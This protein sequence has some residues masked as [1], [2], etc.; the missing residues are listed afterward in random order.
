[1]ILDLIAAASMLLTAPT[2]ISST[3]AAYDGTS[4]KLNGNVELEH[5]LGLM[6]SQEALL[7]KDPF[8]QIHLKDG[9]IITLK[10][11]GKILCSSADLDLDAMEGKLL[12]AEDKKIQFEHEA[13]KLGCLAAEL[14][15][16]HAKEPTLSNMK[17]L[18]EVEI[19]YEGDLSLM[20][21]EATYEKEPVAI[22]TA[23]PGVNA[24]CVI[25]RGDDRMEAKKVQFFPN[26]GKVVIEGPSGSFR[27]ALLGKEGSGQ[28]AFNCGALTLNHLSNRLVLERAVTMSEP[29]IGTIRCNGS[30]AVTQMEK[31]GKHTLETLTTEGD[32]EW[33]HADHFLS[34]QGPLQI[35]N[36]RMEANLGE[37]IE[38]QQGDLKLMADR[39]MMKYAELRPSQLSL[40]GNVRL[41]DKALR[42]ATADSLDYMPETQ[43]VILRANP[44]K[45]VLFWDSEKQMTI[46][47]REVHITH[48]SETKEENV[49]GIGKVQFSFT[50]A[51]SQELQK[52]FPFYRHLEANGH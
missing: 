52:L 14:F 40:E 43:T 27:S 30:I 24:A 3:E 8:S 46:S 38:F 21:G 33:Q 25:R 20:A 2:S 26:E 47:A 36:K 37:S 35:D 4:L 39:G 1:M 18:G 19:D 13:L 42:C 5:D 11:Q 28:M 29:K 31:G 48:D 15:F 49:K 34:C 41:S 16:S 45:K 6:Q 7:E 44:G 12:S 23:Y 50:S 32:V 22:M 10:K 51:E 9:V 17:A